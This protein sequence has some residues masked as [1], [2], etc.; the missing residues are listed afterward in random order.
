MKTKLLVSAAVCALALSSVNTYAG[1]FNHS[2]GGHD[3][4]KVDVKDWNKKFD[5]KDWGKLKDWAKGQDWGKGKDCGTPPP[6]KG[7]NCGAV[8]EI[9]ASSSTLAFGLTAGLIALVRGRRRRQ[10]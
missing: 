9:D 6:C 8:P 7:G 4:K 1:N 2:Y 10:V 5:G 3:F